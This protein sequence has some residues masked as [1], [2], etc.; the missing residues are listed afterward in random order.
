IKLFGFDVFA[1]YARKHSYGTTH[2]F[3]RDIPYDKTGEGWYG[4]V[5]FTGLEG[6]GLTFEYKN[7]RFD[8]VD[9]D[10]RKDANRPTRIVP[11]QNPP[12]VHKEHAF[13]LLTRSPHTIDF[14]DE[15][16]WQVDVFSA[17]A[18][19]LVLN[20]NGAV[21]SRQQSWVRLPGG[22]YRP[23]FKSNDLFPAL[24]EE[25]SPFWEIYLDAEWYFEEES[26]VRLAVNRRSDTQY[27]EGVGKGHRVASTTLPVRIEYMLD[28][29]FSLGVSLEQ[30]WASDNS[31]PVD[32]RTFFNEFVSVTLAHAPDWAATI[33]A[34]F[35]SDEFDPSGKKSWITGEFT[36]RLGNVHT[37]TVSY[38]S[39]RGG[40]ICSSGVCRVV[41]PF[42]GV[43]VQLYTQ[44]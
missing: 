23:L 9:P 30:Q 43:R 35:T 4:S 13:T 24:D 6:F 16:G 12:I 3:S 25:F 7:Y 8:V 22:R 33:R 44:L 17:V 39:E 38:G 2:G 5:S 10:A 32:D 19:N 31:Y 11:V 18:P 29:A 26:F 1:E 21:A 37:A 28:E 15:T 40:L 14:N 27:E 34:E 20:L 41:Q 42:T 36:Y